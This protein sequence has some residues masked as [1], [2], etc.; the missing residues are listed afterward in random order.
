MEIYGFV[1]CWSIRFVRCAK[2]TGYCCKV[3][4]YLEV[5]KKKK[6]KNSKFGAFPKIH[7]FIFTTC[8]DGILIKST[9]IDS[10]THL[11]L[12]LQ[13]VFVSSAFRNTSIC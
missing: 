3:N 9:V 10:R 13:L 2:F 1:G 4:S 8:L 5:K 12:N 11:C 7:Y 6:N